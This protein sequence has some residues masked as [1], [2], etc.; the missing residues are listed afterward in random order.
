MSTRPVS[1]HEESSN[2]RFNKVL[3]IGI[4]AG[5]VVQNAEST[6]GMAGTVDFIN[7]VELHGRAKAKEWKMMKKYIKE[8]NISGVESIIKRK[9]ILLSDKFYSK[10]R[11]ITATEYAIELEK[12]DDDYNAVLMALYK[13]ELK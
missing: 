10:G 3:E 7:N 8:K 13:L 9:G 4:D 5:I 12:K 6:E 1:N 2:S 11:Y